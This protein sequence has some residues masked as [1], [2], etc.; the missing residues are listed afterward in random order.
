MDI[1]LDLI[2][3][4]GPFGVKYA[5]IFHRLGVAFTKTGKFDLAR[6]CFLKAAKCD[7]KYPLGEAF[8]YLRKKH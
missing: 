8:S 5:K 3:H 2:P 7:P 6:S 1:S 4:S